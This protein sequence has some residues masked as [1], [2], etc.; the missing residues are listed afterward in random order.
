MRNLSHFSM[1]FA[2]MN[3]MDYDYM[4]EGLC[5]NCSRYHRCSELI[6]RISI[7]SFFETIGDYSLD[8]FCYGTYIIKVRSC[9]VRLPEVGNEVLNFFEACERGDGVWLVSPGPRRGI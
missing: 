7:D 4:L 3:R 6:K 1:G 5:S 2:E 9:R 8:L